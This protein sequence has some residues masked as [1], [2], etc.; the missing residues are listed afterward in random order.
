[1][2]KTGKTKVQSQDAINP[3]F[4]LVI[5]AAAERRAGIQEASVNKQPAVYILASKR[6]GTLY[7]SAYALAGG[8]LR[9]LVLREV[10]SL[11]S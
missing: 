4:K 9:P 5:P 7:I 2:L 11:S 1:M 6:N 10:R 3:A 8:F